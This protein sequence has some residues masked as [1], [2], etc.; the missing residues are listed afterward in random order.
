MKRKLAFLLALLVVLA[1]AILVVRFLSSRSP[2]LGELR[3]D[4][5][6]T[7]SIFL[8]SKHMG[9]TPFRDKVQAGEYTLKLVTENS[10]EQAAS[11][12]G[13]ITIG[14]NLLTYINATLSDSELTSAVDVLWLEKISSKQSELSVVTNPDGATVMVDE[15]TKGVTPLVVSDVPPG[16]HTVSIASPGFLPRTLR[17]KTT[18]GYK[19]IASMKLALGSGASIPTAAVSPVPSGSPTATPTKTATSSASTV[20]DPEKPF[21]LIKDTPTGF[22]RVRTEPST[23]ATE[24][25][26]VNP[27]EKYHFF[28]EKSGWY[29]IEYQAAKK[30]WVSG[31]YA[32]KVE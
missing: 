27:G 11:W 30:G 22:L 8:D 2:K 12:Q 24:A 3:V 20:P 23:S 15:Q 10:L 28:S 21:I 13:K 17:V 14:H 26:R 29:E 18:P 9:R 25:A 4:S 32:E 19:L 7:V 16:D 6:P 1:L 31:Q 5:V